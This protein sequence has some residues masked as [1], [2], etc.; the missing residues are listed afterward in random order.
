VEIGHFLPAVATLLMLFF[1]FDRDCLGARVL[2]ARGLRFTGIVSYEWFLFH[3]PIVG[4]FHGHTGATHGSVM[5]Y[6]WRTVAPLATTFVFAVLVYRW[7]SLPILNW[8]RDKVKAAGGVTV[9]KSKRA[10]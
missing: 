10:S 3:G 6:A 5:A 4:W 1:V 2:S 8:A 7:F 9:E